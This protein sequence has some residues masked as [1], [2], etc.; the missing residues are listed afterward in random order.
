[1]ESDV[2]DLEEKLLSTLGTNATLSM[3]EYLDYSIFNFNSRI[4]ILM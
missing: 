4:L 1:M 2:S 3:S